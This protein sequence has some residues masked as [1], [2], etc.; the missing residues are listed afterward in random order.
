VKGLL[1]RWDAIA[2]LWLAALVGEIS[3]WLPEQVPTHWNHLGHIDGWTPRGQLVWFVAGVPVFVWSITVGLDAMQR[4]TA[5]GKGAPVVG[6]GPLR[7]GIVSGISVFSLAVCMAPLLGNK[8]VLGPLI[9]LFA[10]LGFGLWHVGRRAQAA[11]ATQ[12]DA[13]HWK[14]GLFYHNTGDSRLWVDKRIGYGWTLNLAKPVAK[15]LLA[16]AVAPPLVL[17]AVLASLAR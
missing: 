3:A 10:C 5:K 2:A 12:P 17:V 14:Y 1:D 9:A 16:V 4:S 11:M 13:A 15:V 8:S 7:F 6:L